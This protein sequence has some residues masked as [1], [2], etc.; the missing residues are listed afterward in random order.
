MSSTIRVL[1]VFGALNRGGAETMIMNIYRNINRDK[2]QFDFMMHCSGN[3]DYTDEIRSLGGKIYSIPRF[4][5]ENYVHYKEAWNNFFEGHP[6]YKMIHGHVR[7]TAEIYLK[8][9]KKH[10]LITIAHSHS[11]SNGAGFLAI[12]KNMMQYPVRYRADYLFA[13]S[14][15]AGKW[16]YGKKAVQNSN[17]KMIRNAIDISKYSYNQELRKTKRTDLNVSDK[18]VIGHVGR[19]QSP[20]NHMF[21]LDLFK[22]IHCKNSNIVL[23]LVGDGELRPQIEKKIADLGLENCVILT[24]VRSDVPELMQAMDV[25]AFPSL[26]E[27]LG[28]VAIEAQAAGLP[29]V[30]SDA[31]PQEAFITDLIQSVPLADSA[32]IWA[33][34]I[35]KYRGGYER[36]DTSEQIKAA[37]YD[38]G[39]S[40]KELEN[41]YL[42]VSNGTDSVL[43]HV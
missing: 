27:G 6:E 34:E 11:T 2:I 35:L 25:F 21:L 17:F 14:E 39:N 18:F 10:K 36:Q 7:S 23:L 22:E 13:C 9:A 26:Y 30:V 31:V 20:K 1:H 29:C 12:I 43:R 4:T 5:G 37:G 42:G 19:F 8:I 41:F 3:C 33:D 32:Q 16:M 15:E 40:A 38:I 24:G 28:I